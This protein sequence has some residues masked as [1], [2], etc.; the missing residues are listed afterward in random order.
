M[1]REE[2]FTHSKERSGCVHSIFP[3]YALFEVLDA[4]RIYA[5]EGFIANGA[6]ELRGPDYGRFSKP[7]QKAVL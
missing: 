4:E 3:V 5:H 2:S 7:S 6:G 1:E